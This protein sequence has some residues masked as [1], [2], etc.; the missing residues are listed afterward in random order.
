[1]G[2]SERRSLAMILTAGHL[3]DASRTTNK[4]NAFVP[5]PTENKIIVAVMVSGITH[6]LH[7]INWDFFTFEPGHCASNASHLNHYTIARAVTTTIIV[8]SSNFFGAKI[9]LYAYRWSLSAVESGH[10]NL[11]LTCHTILPPRL[12]RL[13][14]K[15]TA[16]RSMMLMKSRGLKTLS[17][18]KITSGY[19]DKYQTKKFIKLSILTLIRVGR[20][21]PTN[22]SQYLRDIF[23]IKNSK[24]GLLFTSVKST[25]TEL[26]EIVINRQSDDQMRH[27][28][29]CRVVW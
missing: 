4:A 27:P 18:R 1:M 12:T 5:S 22:H 21:I 16:H 7:V 14:K 3:N 10:S 29:E 6:F 9:I 23:H 15:I 25:S 24:R 28:D 11:A 8:M 26:P 19:G 13:K 20:E 17:H 2:R